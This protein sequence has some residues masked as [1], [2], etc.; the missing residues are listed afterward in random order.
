[1]I[2]TDTGVAPAIFEDESKE[3]AA[4]ITILGRLLPEG[5][6]ITVAH[7]VG[8]PSVVAVTYP[9]GSISTKEFQGSTLH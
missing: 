6:T 3:I 4:A 7:A 8:L 9:D 1:M 5:M 2:A